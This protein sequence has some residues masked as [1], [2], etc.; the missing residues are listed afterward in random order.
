MISAQ[1]LISILPS[2]R[3]RY[4]VGAPLAQYTWFRVGG[5][6]Q[7][8]FKPADVTDLA[9]FLRH[10]PRDVPIYTLG[11]GSNLLVRDGGVPGVVIRLGRGFSNIA[12]KGADL[13]LG[14]AVLDRTAS[15]VARDEAMTGLEFLCSIPGTIGGGLRMNAG[16]YG[17]EMRDVLQV[18]IALDERGELHKLTNEDM[19]FSYRHCAIPEDWIFVGARLKTKH[20]K[21]EQI[22]ETMNT[23]LAQRDETQP[24]RTRTGGSTFANPAGLKAWELI[25]QAGC[26]G[27][28]R[29]GAMISE[30]HCNFLLN[31]GEATAEDLEELAEEV[32]RRVFAQTGV[33][34]R[35]EIQRIGQKNTFMA[36]EH[37]EVKAA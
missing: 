19:G 10:R 35:W 24:V 27:L 22:S 28:A 4:V 2:V 17:S 7:V 23:M 3:G 20:G 14:G 29:G 25:D 37:P 12:L 26:R 16:C 34:L 9:F 15:L 21:V 1:E 30:K 36:Y 11:V 5:P 33:T 8:L 13:E 32:R 18:A 31:T 6:A